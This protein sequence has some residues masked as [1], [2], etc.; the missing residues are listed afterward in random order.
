MKNEFITLSDLLSVLKSR[1]LP[2]LLAALLCGAL[3]YGATCLM[4]KE[5]SATSSFYVKNM[6]NGDYTDRNGVTSSQ[7]AAAQAMAQDFSAIIPHSD[8]LLERAI[9]KHD[10]GCTA[11]KL[12]SMLET[13]ADNKS[14]SFYVKVTCEDKEF[15]LRAARA[16]EAELPAAITELAWNVSTI[17]GDFTCV[18]VLEKA[19][20]AHQSAPRYK[21]LTAMGAAAG[22][23][24]TY[25]VFLLVFLFGTTVRTEEDVARA[26]PDYPILGR[27]P[28]WG[29][30]DIKQKEEE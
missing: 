6:P 24:L 11:G 12:R 23:L 13:E 26:L 5:Y 21:L 17:E 8:L 1:L 9:D 14:A 10:L 7:I 19:S 30:P 20:G 25:I 2:I 3:T 22:A 4:P 29:S 16:I 28:R 18:T 27:I 15:A